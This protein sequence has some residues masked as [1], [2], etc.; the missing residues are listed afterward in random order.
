MRLPPLCAIL[1]VDV[2]TAHGWTVPDLARA[3]LDGGARFLQVRAK[4][5]PSGRFLEIADA[6]VALADAVG[7]T[8]VV[9]DRADIARLARAA[10]VHVGQSDLAPG[11]CRELLGAG[12]LIGLSTSTR[13]EVDAAFVEDVTYVAIGPVF[14]TGTK[15]DSGEPVGL[16]MV[17]HV[18]ARAA[19]VAERPHAAVPII[20]IG[21]ITLERAPAVIAAGAASVAV[22]SDLF[23]GG[24]PAARTDAYVAAL[25]G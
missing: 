23:T 15:P 24:D 11:A 5:V 3:C 20:A 17:R 13:A 14:A 22:I 6:V 10:G 9:N 25:G 7:A 21:G 12:A 4:R 8:V 19:A 18:T 16:D 1:D 2:A